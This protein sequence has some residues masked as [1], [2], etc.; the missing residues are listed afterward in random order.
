MFLDF[1][2]VCRVFATGFR[3][4]GWFRGFGFRAGVEDR[5]FSDPKT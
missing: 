4:E 1:W 3:V 2:H 5:L